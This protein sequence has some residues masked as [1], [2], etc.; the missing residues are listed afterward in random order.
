[1]IA[2]LMFLFLG[3]VRIKVKSEIGKF[4]TYVTKESLRFKT[5]QKEE[6]TFV[7]L[8]K[9][10]KAAEEFAKNNGI[11][12]E[13]Y[14]ERGIPRIFK[15]Y[16]KRVGVYI[17]VA[18]FALIVWYSGRIVWYIDITGNTSVESSEIIENLEKLGFTYGSDFKKLDF[19]ALRRR[20][21]IDNDDLSW[22]S[23]NMKGTHAHV[24]VRELR[25]GDEN[26]TEGLCNVVASESGKIVIV[27]AEEGK[28][29]VFPG[30][31]V[32]KGDLL[33]GCVMTSGEDRL[34]FERAKGR[35]L[36]EV[37]RSFSFTV[38][39]EKEISTLTGG[40][41]SEKELVF[42]KNNIKISRNCRIP[43]QF[44]DTIDEVKY[45]YLP[46]GL[47]L[48]LGIRNVTYREIQK[49]RVKLSASD[50]SAEAEKIFNEYLAD[51]LG[52]A[53]LLSFVREDQNDENGYTVKC[54]AVC[55]ADIA[56]GIEVA[57]NRDGADSE[58]D[59]VN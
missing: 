55:L 1:M 13:V 50:S 57:D 43:Y 30:D 36:A 25:L 41:M 51:V 2:F 53:E 29:C 10:A 28:P 4:M 46:K 56:C 39:S 31:Y 48:P 14:R 27:E 20:Y 26:V 42:F 24:E 45:L 19:D 34:R 17:G 21:M 35:V 18:V 8:L 6:N 12:I 7:F 54:D 16:G 47:M 33:I 58:N 23:I 32:S 5:V 15:R 9:H 3:S 52:D 44:Y 59:T 37:K 22:L 40:E 11:E 38:P 49:D